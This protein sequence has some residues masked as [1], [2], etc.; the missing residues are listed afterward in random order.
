MNSD[1]STLNSSPGQLGAA[2]P[3]FALAGIGLLLVVFWGLDEGDQRK[4]ELSATGQAARQELAA[5]PRLG[6]TRDEIESFLG[7]PLQLDVPADPA[8][9]GNVFLSAMMRMAAEAPDHLGDRAAVQMALLSMGAPHLLPS[10]TYKIGDL[11]YEIWYLHDVVV[12]FTVSAGPRPKIVG[13]ELLRREELEY[14]I[15][16]DDYVLQLLE[17]NQSDHVGHRVEWSQFRAGVR[18][19]DLL[20]GDFLNTPWTMYRWDAQDRFALWQQSVFV[21]VSREFVQFAETENSCE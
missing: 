14:L 7:M 6:Q 2:I 20:R 8:M 1:Q 3:F 15:L 12:M 5:L 13:K 9:S 10:D 21:I 17:A 16:T 11:S 4:D 19:D 18:G